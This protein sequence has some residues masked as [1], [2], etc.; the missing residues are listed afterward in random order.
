MILMAYDTRWDKIGKALE[1]INLD[2]FEFREYQAN[3]INSIF[4]H[5]NTLVVLPTGL[6]KTV[7]GIGIIADSLSKGRKALL[8]APTKPLAEQHYNNLLDRLRVPKEKI[9]LF[10]GKIG[11]TSRKELALNAS[12]IVATPQTI[13][14]DLKQANMSLM[15][16]GCAIFDECHRA[17]GRY[18]YTYIANECS[19]N[20][21][22]IVGLTA[23]PGS[24]KEKINAL[25]KTLNIRHIEIRISSDPDVS[26]YVMSKEMHIKTVGK[27]PTME[28]IAALMR[29]KIEE[30]L[31]GLNKMG[32]LHFR[33]FESI[34]KGRLLQAGTEISKL[35]A[36]NYKYAALFNYVKLLHLSHAYDL[37][38]TEGIYPFSK[39][40]E[41][42]EKREKKSRSV[43]HI[44][45][46][47]NI[48][49]ARNLAREA[50]ERGEEHPKVL[51]ALDIIKS[52]SQKS[53]II[54][55]QYRTTIKMLTDYLN[56]AGYS[57]M[58][59]VGKKEGMTQQL[60]EQTI[61]DFR[62]GKFKVLVAS[63]IGE[64]GLDIPSVDVVIF[65]E[66]IPNEIR[67]IQRRGR[68]GRF[69]TGDIYVL[70]TRGTKDEVYFYISGQ[71]ERKMFGLVRA[72]N[73][74]M[75]L[76][77]NGEA[78]NQKML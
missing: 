4:K 5:G 31:S 63:S 26:K 41:A 16:F 14:N 8:L 68:T 27:T 47:E 45:G 36:P 6:G 35:Q 18:A 30:S 38:L 3:I 77:R 13:A 43:E 25:V 24:K 32:F 62:N 61:Q 29:P 33:N 19:I 73:E 65:Y 49:K 71:K 75:E 42:L 57:A 15:D 53:T 37:L 66:P 28:S 22:L 39:Y 7:I 56:G 60:Q 9:A 1:Y 52:N 70:I 48:I 17:V 23:S 40:F 67:N 54:F 50:I 59:F 69:R 78:R 76:K 20:D 55:A 72:I 44:L 51:A 74:K 21:V 10:T 12:V 46:N 64:E 2:G 11:K 58:Q 34:P